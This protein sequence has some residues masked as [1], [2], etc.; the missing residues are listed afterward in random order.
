MAT[1]TV[2]I[3]C[4]NEVHVLYSCNGCTTSVSLPV[5]IRSMALAHTHTHMHGLLGIAPL[6][7]HVCTIVMIKS[8]STHWELKWCL[9]CRRSRGYYAWVHEV[10]RLLL[11]QIMAKLLPFSYDSSTFKNKS[12]FC[13][14][15]MECVRQSIDFLSFLQH[16]LYLSFWLSSS[17]SVF[18]LSLISWFRTFLIK[19]STLL[20][21]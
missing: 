9:V 5:H 18:S 14:F 13:I 10:I 12:I 19:N 3:R 8:V 21:R 4:Q 2:F 6:P 20:P 1:C 16:T 7:L 17:T 15:H 11:E